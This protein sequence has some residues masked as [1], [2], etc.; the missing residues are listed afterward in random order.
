MPF[1]AAVKK[2]KTWG[3]MSSYNRL[4]GTFTSENE[5]LLTQVL[6]GGWHYD[7]VVMS[8]WFGSHSTA[9]TVNAELDLEMPGPPRDRGAKLVAAVEAGEVTAATMRERTL[10]ILR[11]MERTS[12]LDDHRPHEERAKDRPAHR[13]LIR[14]AGAEGMVLLKNDG[15][16]PLS[17]SGKVA[18]IG[19]NAKVA[20]IMGGGSAQ[21]NPYYR[22]SPYD[23]LVAALGADRLVYAAGAGNNRFEPLIEGSFTV[24]YFANTDMSGA[25]VHTETQQNAEAFWIGQ[26]AQGKV[27]PLRFSARIS[28]SF[29]ASPSRANTT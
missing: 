13:A 8:D 12:A 9:P 1:E 14:R 18:V 26:V 27:D 16:L 28:G 11:W 7:G 3:V 10:N 17:G 20:Q 19:P 23:G 5:W 4:N 25:P 6:R 24:D 2:G 15:V 22:V 29:T 21:L